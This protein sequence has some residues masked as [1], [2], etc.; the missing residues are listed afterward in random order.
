MKVPIETVRGTPYEMGLQQG[1]IFR[2]LIHANVA[3][4]AMRHTFEGSDELLDA[5]MA[6]QRAIQEELCP[7]VFEELRGIAEGSGVDLPW[8]ERLHMRIWNALPNQPY[9]GDAGGCTIVGMKTPDGVAVAG[10]LD[11]PRS[12]YVLLRRIP[13]DGIPHI[14]TVWAGTAWGHNGCNE[15]GLS[16]AQASGG[17]FEGGKMPTP[18]VQLRIEMVLRLMLTNCATVPEALKVMAGHRQGCSLVLGDAQGNLMLQ[19]EAAVAAVLDADDAGGMVYASNH[20]Y[21]PAVVEHLARHGVR[22]VL[23]DYSRCRFEVLEQARKTV[24][25]TV[26]G[27]KDLLRSHERFPHSI[28]NNMSCWINLMLPEK[29]PGVFHL[30]DKPPCRSEFAAYPVRE[31]AGA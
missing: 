12:S 31:M 19:Q 6:G 4:W 8:I 3:Q 10:V 23:S 25:R 29:E 16:L 15:V 20:M 14:S 1:R 22:P 26:A 11:D 18:A 17:N 2:H 30:C 13:K 27:L 21:L 7:W 28:C 9:P 5:T 24:P